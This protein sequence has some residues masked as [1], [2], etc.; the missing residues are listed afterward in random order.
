MSS[1]EDVKMKLARTLS[2]INWKPTKESARV[3]DFMKSMIEIDIEMPDQGT[4]EVLVV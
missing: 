2:D 3:S 4:G 1:C